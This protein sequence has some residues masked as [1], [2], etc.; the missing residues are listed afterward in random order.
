MARK[1][2]IISRSEAF[3]III[4]TVALKELL[5]D[6]VGYL[7]GQRWILPSW[8]QRQAVVVSSS[9]SSRRRIRS[10]SK[11][12]SSK[13]TSCHSVCTYKNPTVPDGMMRMAVS[14]LCPQR[15]QLEMS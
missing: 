15:Y 11:V 7:V 2:A 4:I 12:I 13:F 3:V 5:R 14:W 8:A 1:F 6:N 10:S 9:S